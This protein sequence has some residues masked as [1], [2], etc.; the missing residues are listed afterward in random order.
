MGC[1]ARKMRC[2]ATE[3]G[4]Q[5]NVQL[6]WELSWVAVAVQLLGGGATEV[7][8]CAIKIGSAFGLR[9]GCSQLQCAPRGLKTGRVRLKKWQSWRVAVGEIE[10]PFFSCTLPVFNVTGEM[11]VPQCWYFVGTFFVSEFY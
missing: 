3:V 6:S 8:C 2:R 1:G 10:L 11:L 5:C 4:L 7:D 9:L